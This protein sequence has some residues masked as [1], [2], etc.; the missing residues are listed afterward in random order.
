[1]VDLVVLNGPCAGACFAIPDVPVVVGRS[2][3]ANFQIDDPWISN[4]HALIE[5]RGEELW[6]VDLGSRNGTFVDEL[7]VTEARLLK[8]TSLAF[9]RT[10]LELR[11]RSAASNRDSKLM[12]T[13]YRRKHVSVTVP[14]EASPRPSR[15][16]D[17]APGERPSG[18]ASTVPERPR[19]GSRPAASGG[20]GR[21]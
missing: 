17:S 19:T 11:A 15:E 18:R 16:D 4:M 12:K 13:P 8:G 14:Q 6:V 5:R 1:M 21:R 10:R 2:L 3:E 20:R 7:P 9:G